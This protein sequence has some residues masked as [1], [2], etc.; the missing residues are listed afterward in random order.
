[1]YATWVRAR[2]ALSI[3]FVGMFCLTGT[4][5]ADDPD[6]TAESRATCVEPKIEQPF[7]SIGDLRDYVLAPGGDFADPALSGWD[8]DDGASVVA[9]SLRLPPGASATSPTMCVDLHW[10]TMRF[11]VLQEARRDAELDVEVFYPQAGKKADWKKVGEIEA[12]SSDGWHAT[13]DIQLLPRLGGK[14]PGARQVALRFTS[15]DDD[16]GTWRIDDVYLDPK[17][18]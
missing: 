4:A 3:A 15:D 14:L 1:M 11:M 13:D 6:T 8:L 18:L 16:R 5:W 9:Q 17:R 2:R 7:A 10:P 12:R